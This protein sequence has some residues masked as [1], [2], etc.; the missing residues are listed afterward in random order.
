MHKTMIAILLVGVLAISAQAEEFFLK[1]DETGKVYGPYS[2]ESGSKIEIEGAV[3]IIA[4][5]SSKAEKILADMVITELRFRNASFEDC[6]QFLIVKTRELNSDG[7]GMNFVIAKAPESKAS[8]ANERTTDSFGF[9][10]PEIAM[11]PRITLSLRN[12]SVLQALKSLMDQTGF[13]YKT[14]DNLIT[15][16]PN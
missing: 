9:A 4:K 6:V 5:E 14:T 16:F 2:S 15:I 12:V 8:L 13:S 11:G 3:Y 10:K 7:V 1:N